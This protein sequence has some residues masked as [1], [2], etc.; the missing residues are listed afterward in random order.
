[1]IIRKYGEND[2]PAMITVWN[3][4]VAEGNA[5]PQEELLDARSGANFFASQS[6]CGVADDC[7]SIVGL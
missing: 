1:M 6:Y 7:G 3:E 2:L 4:I 5:F